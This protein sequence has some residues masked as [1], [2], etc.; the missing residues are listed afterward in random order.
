MNAAGKAALDLQ[1][2]AG[3]LC[4]GFC[5]GGELALLLWRAGGDGQGFRCAG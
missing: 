1:A 4:G 3:G 5:Q 2:F